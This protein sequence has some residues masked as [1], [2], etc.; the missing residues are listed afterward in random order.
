MVEN[1]MLSLRSTLY[2]APFSTVHRHRDNVPSLLNWLDFL[3]CGS[4]RPRGSSWPDHDFT[5]CRRIMY[6][7][8]NI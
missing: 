3:G 6:T 1:A 7:Y 8:M 4:W 5:S 2:P